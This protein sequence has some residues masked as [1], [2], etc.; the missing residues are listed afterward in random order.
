V[1]QGAQE[2]LGYSMAELERLTPLDIKPEFTAV[3]FSKLL[4]PLHSG[5]E[6]R[7]EF[8][9]VHLRKDG[10]QYPVEVFLQLSELGFD[11]VIVAIILDISERKKAEEMI[12]Q[13]DRLSV[14]GQ[15]AS[16][17]AHDFNNI[18][19]VII[20]YSELLLK[21]ADLTSEGQQK[22]RTIQQQAHHASNLTNQILDFSRQSIMERRPVDLLPFLKEL[23]VLLERTLPE[24]IKIKFVWTAGD[25][26][27]V[28]A[29][30]NRIQQAL[31]NLAVNA[32]DAMLAGG[33]LEI[34]MER[35]HFGVDDDVPTAE[36]AG[37]EWVKIKLSDSGTGIAPEMTPHIFEPF[38]TTKS[39][40][41]GTGLGLAQV[42]GIVKQHGGLIFVDSALN[43]GTTFSL[44]IPASFEM[45]SMQAEVMISGALN[46][47]NQ[48]LILV[49][50]DEI[51]IRRAL[52]ES[53][54]LLNYKVLVAGNGREALAVFDERPDIDLVVSDVVMPE[55]G[56][57]KLL[58]ALNERQI[59]VPVLMLTG[60]LMGEN[61]DDLKAQGLTE[62]L[63]KPVQLD[64]LAETVS[65]LLNGPAA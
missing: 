15:L 25:S 65:R 34:E 2:N 37:G 53:L 43:K 49:V 40:G 23:V 55:M 4:A 51:M 9:T 29:D 39:P 35:V 50:E 17:I 14:V 58:Q 60:H 10:S 18:L 46:E 48:E 36:M 11:Q 1:N 27:V 22:L 41:V 8:V 38:F 56:G 47:G 30:L 7:I 57:L 20:L 45:E 13:Q 44:F 64:V 32:R 33:E 21:T 19:G 63:T 6:E 3:C 31:M 62:W 52:E 42:Y 59:K 24:D 28:N 26:F 61:L 54:E 16:G 5:E 12:R